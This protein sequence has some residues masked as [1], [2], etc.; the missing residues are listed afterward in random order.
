MVLIATNRLILPIP[1][2]IPPDGSG[3]GNK[4]AALAPVVSSGSQT[5]NTP[6]ATQWRLKFDPTTDEHWM[7]GVQVP[8]DYASGG[9]LKLRFGSDATT[10]NVV[11]K[12][13]VALADIT[14]NTDT[15]SFVFIAG[16]VSSATAVHATSGA[17]VAVDITL[18]VT[19]VAAGDGIVIFI[20]RDADNASDTV[21]S[22]DCWLTSV[23]P[24]ILEYTT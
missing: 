19:S 10:G 22:N 11:W 15:D 2:G 17:L 14:A 9:T 7:W 16:D 4:A 12:A 8:G 20:G 13:G 1:G 6:K 23:A 18:T 24:P 5:T 21:N 3:S